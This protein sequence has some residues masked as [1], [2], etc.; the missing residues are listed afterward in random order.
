VRLIAIALVIPESTIVVQARHAF[1]T[2]Q[3]TLVKKGH[4]DARDPA[5]E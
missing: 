1:T 5:A 2:E 4:A 3:F